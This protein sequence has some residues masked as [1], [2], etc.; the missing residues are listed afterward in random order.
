MSVFSR[1]E[2]VAVSTKLSQEELFT[3]LKEGCNAALTEGL[4]ALL[5]A[6]RFALKGDDVTE[7]MSFNSKMNEFAE[8]NFSQLKVSRSPIGATSA[9]RVEVSILTDD[10]WSKASYLCLKTS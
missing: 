4:R 1:N 5:Y 9:E 8:S 3:D 7:V 6:R 10:G 2:R